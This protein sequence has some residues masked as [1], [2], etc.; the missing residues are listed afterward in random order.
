MATTEEYIIG[1]LSVDLKFKK[2]YK[3]YVLSVGQRFKMAMSA[4]IWNATNKTQGH[5]WKMI[6]II[7]TEI[8]KWLNSNFVYRV[9]IYNQVR[10]TDTAE[11]LVLQ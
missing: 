5:Y 4:N 11:P 3:I 10:D 1:V 6:K 2:K 7:S 8:M 9:V